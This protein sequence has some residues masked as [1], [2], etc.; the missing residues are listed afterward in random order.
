MNAPYE[1]IG[2]SGA[3]MD[4]RLAPRRKKGKLIGLAALVA[5]A[6]AIGVATATAP[7]GLRVEAGSVK[8]A[9]VSSGMFNDDVV[10]R[11]NVEPLNSVVLDSIESGRVEEVFVRDG[12]LVKQ[13]DLLFRLSNSQR[14]MELLQRQS[15]QSQ[16]L[17]NLANLQVTFE[18]ARNAHAERINHL[19]FALDQAEKQHARNVELASK[20][21]VS[22]ATVQES[23]DRLAEAR[24]TLHSEQASGASE[25]GVRKA[26][27]RTMTGAIKGLESGMQLANSSI[28]A[29][30]MRAPTSGRLTDFNLRV[31]EAVRGD[32]R[33]GRIDDLQFKLLAQVDEYYLN[34]VTVGGRGMAMA[35]NK[36]YVVE[37]SRIYQ[38]VKDRRFSVE[39]S[40]KKEMPVDLQPGMSVDARLTLGEPTPAMVLPSG[41]YLNDS[42]GAW[43]FV[44]ATDGAS[45]ERR[46]VRVGRRNNSQVEIASGLKPGERVI[47]S[48]YSAYGQ[49]ERLQLQQ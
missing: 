16:Q 41:P 24:R 4:V 27:M 11:A 32:Q 6:G 46:A 22:A 28:G 26:A 2:I 13:G 20:G 1:P 17:S 7:R 21:F 30:A 47:V 15:E 33:L 8:L 10:V 14:Q 31:G 12:A 42:G 44:A 36:S 45:A 25:L 43:V 39:L 29:L 9:T 3:G 48:S 23:R 35:N 34:R 5:L 40:F 19:H 38:Q 49:A 18:V 37:V